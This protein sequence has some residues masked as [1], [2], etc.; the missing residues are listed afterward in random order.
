MLLRYAIGSALRRI[1]LDRE[2][3][4]RTVAD[5]ARISMP[6]LSEIERGRKEPSS[7][8]LGSVAQAL[9]LELLDVVARVAGRLGTV[10]DERVRNEHEAQT[11]RRAA[12]LDVTGP[13]Q[14]HPLDLA[15]AGEVHRLSGVAGPGASS[16]E[17]FLLVA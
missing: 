2:L 9:G 17:V 12:P 11:R 8:V 3:T 13:A 7:E 1:R 16:A 4:L 14:A 10:R 15:G 5:T 6:Y